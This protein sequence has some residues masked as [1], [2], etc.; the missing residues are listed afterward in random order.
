MSVLSGSIDIRA[1]LRRTNANALST[2]SEDCSY[3]I[4][5]SL[6]NGTGVGEAMY[7]YS[8]RLSLAAAPQTLDIYGGLTDGLGTTLNFATVRA[9]IVHNRSSTAGHVLTIGNAASNQFASFLGAA[10]ETVIVRPGGTIVL[11]APRD[12]Y[13]VVQSSADLLKLDPG[14][15]TFDAD[16]IIVGT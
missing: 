10:N 7:F 15:N 16:V 12:G 2:P 8:R 13:T 9:L 1:A 14:A 5:Q 4:A 6:A 11:L 3:S